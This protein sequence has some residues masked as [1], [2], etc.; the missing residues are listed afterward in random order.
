[1]GKPAGVVENYVVWSHVLI[2]SVG[3]E[4]FCVKVKETQEGRLSVSKITVFFFFYIYLE[5]EVLDHMSIL[6]L[7]LLEISRLFSKMCTILYSKQQ[8]VR[9]LKSPHPQRYLL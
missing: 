1:M 7:N 6:C 4:V 3:N 5:E 8:C 9:V 2:R